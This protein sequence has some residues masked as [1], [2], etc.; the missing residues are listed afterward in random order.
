ML[1][2]ADFSNLYKMC[3]SLS[4]IND[5]AKYRLNIPPDRADHLRDAY[6]HGQLISKLAALKHLNQLSKMNTIVLG[7]WH[8][9]L[10]YILN[11][12]GVS[13]KTVGVELDHFW[14][15]FCL[16]LELPNYIGVHGDATDSNVWR[17]YLQSNNNIIINTS[18]EHMN[19]DWLNFDRLDTS[20]YIY[21]QGNNYKIPEHI[22][23]CTSLTEFADS[24]SQRGL[25]IHSQHE[26]E[27]HPY[28]RYCVLASWN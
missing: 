2:D 23:T 21:A 4:H 22:N 8:G 10:A 19:W 5:I 7:Q 3:S 27:F 14:H 18:C 12:F 20:G 25:T 24:F 26:I 17:E 13:H 1:K 15:D 28:N 16:N 11:K 6:S 9:L